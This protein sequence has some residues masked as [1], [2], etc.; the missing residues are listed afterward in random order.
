VTGITGTRLFDLLPAIHRLRDSER[1]GALKALLSVIER[2]VALVESDISRLYDN[3][4]VETC[5]EWVVAY[6]GDLLG[7]RGLAPLDGDVFTQRAFVANTIG[8]RR[9]KGT[10]SV[11]EQLG[12][13][14]TGWPSHVVEYFFLLEWTQYSNHLRQLNVRTPDLR[15]TDALE[16]LGGPF[17]TAAHTVDIRHIDSGRGRYNIPN[18]GLFLWR[19]QPYAIELGAGRQVGFPGQ[20][21]YTF[22]P[23]G[24]DIPL[25]NTPRT[26]VE[27]TQISREENVPGRLRRRALYDELHAWRQALVDGA[28]PTSVFFG[29][30]APGPVFEVT[31][32]DDPDPI[33]PENVLICNLDDW[34]RPKKNESYV[35]A[36]DGAVKLRQIRVAVDPVLGRL[37]FPK[38]ITH[39]RTR[40]SFAYGFS[41]DVGGGPYD[42][43]SSLLAAQGAADPPWHDDEID[44]QMGVSAEIP[45][46]PHEVVPT[47]A[48]AVHAWNVQP[49]GTVG[50]ITLMD[51]ASYQE[52]LTGVSRTIL[53]P[54]GSKLLLVAATW[55][56]V[57]DPGVPGGVRRDVGRY[58]ADG[59]RPHLRGDVAIRG[60][61]GGGP[62]TAGG[63]LIVD[64]LLIE[65]KVTVAG[66]D[67]GGLVLSNCTVV[68]GRGGLT[69]IAG[70]MPPLLN[71]HLTVQLRRSICGHIRCAE[72]VPALSVEDGVVDGTQDPG[73]DAITAPGTGMDVQT[74]TVLGTVNCKTLDAGNSIF[75][76]LV[77]VTRRQ[78][79]CVRFCYLPLAS[80]TAR[81]YRCQPI[82]EE[83]ARR[84]FPQFTSTELPHPAY[85]Q[86]AARCPTEITEGAEDEGEMGTFHFLQQGRRVKNLTANLDQYL[87]F[88]LEAGIFFAT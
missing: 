7:V 79:G 85:L 14:V 87:R 47:I 2:E 11:L 65:G 67:L 10:A 81:R 36:A 52:N 62:A 19:L 82:D 45:P 20:E 60:T 26:E 12:R 38:G 29:P 64:G 43:R 48:E 80:V 56:E 63:L 28:K 34:R 73:S 53:V 32:D 70:L 31:V 13:D 42:R 86:L 17:E 22:D 35:R 57:S 30:D 51:S 74:T 55:P 76:E 58:V 88:G 39:A 59:V 5:D 77:T 8:Y 33:P 25:F 50:V 27:S 41:G 78:A 68:P 16:L 66:G 75:R 23:V 83:S 18:V 21:R 71:N 15:G 3:W 40:V 1:D 46:V 44:W 54:E 4:F 24:R 9:R 6:V 84:V 37:T 72:T 49:P 61:S 69:V